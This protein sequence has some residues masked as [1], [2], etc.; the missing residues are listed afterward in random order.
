[1]C[2]R[3]IREEWSPVK[4]E[5]VLIEIDVD[6]VMSDTA[7]MK[8]EEKLESLHTEKPL[9]EDLELGQIRCSPKI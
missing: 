7:L 4:T 6:K 1:M 2:L 8:I 5:Y 9:L 3:E